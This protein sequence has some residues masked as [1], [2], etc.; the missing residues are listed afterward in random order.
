M[1]MFMTILLLGAIAGSLRAQEIRAQEVHAAFV[2]QPYITRGDLAASRFWSPSTIA[3]VALDGA[4]KAADCLATR[5]NIAAG[6][7]EYDPLARPFV[8]TTGV[9]V[10]AAALFGAE[11]ATAYVLHR[12]RHD[13]LG[14]AV[15]VGGTAMNG[16]G[17][18]SSY[19]H[20]VAGW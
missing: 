18:A 5:E 4:A 2:V 16:L 17:A 20:R 14:R 6:G 1:K 3:L 9:L 19:K 12:R 7:E 13:N 11:I 15:L 8:H 10:A